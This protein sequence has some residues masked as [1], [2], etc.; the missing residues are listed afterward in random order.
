MQVDFTAEELAAIAWSFHVR[1]ALLEPDEW[2]AV[3]R[4]IVTK[5]EQ[6]TGN[7]SPEPDITLCC[8]PDPAGDEVEDDSEHVVV[9][10]LSQALRNEVAELVKL[11]AATK[12]RYVTVPDEH[13]QSLRT[14]AAPGSSDSATCGSKASTSTGGSSVTAYADQVAATNSLGVNDALL[15]VAIVLIMLG[16]VIHNAITAR[17]DV[18]WFGDAMLAA[19]RIP[20]GFVAMLVFLAILVVGFIYEW[21]KGALEW[22]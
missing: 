1:H 17:I 2:P 6:V 10:R 4:S 12:R 16:P 7:R 8:Q 13:T 20:F 3:H 18:G 14:A 22:E 5:V 21:K 15:V 9:L 11:C 19:F